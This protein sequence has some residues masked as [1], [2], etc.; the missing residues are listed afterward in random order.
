MLR[1]AAVAW[2]VLCIHCF[3]KYT[4]ETPNT[5]RITLRI[6]L[7]MYIQIVLGNWNDDNG[8]VEFML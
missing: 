8:K 1:V 5:V 7:T 2:A 6:I 4:V 3:I